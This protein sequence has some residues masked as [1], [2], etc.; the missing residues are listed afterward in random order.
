[1]SFGGN[2]SAMTALSSVV[3]LV[4]DAVD[5]INGMRVRVGGATQSSGHSRSGAFACFVSLLIECSDKIRSSLSR[6]RMEL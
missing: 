5:T 6:S 1:M 4:G 2:F 3:I